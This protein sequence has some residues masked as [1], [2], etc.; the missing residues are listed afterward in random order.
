M[1]VGVGCGSGFRR[2]A[3]SEGLLLYYSLPDSDGATSEPS[4]SSLPC[5]R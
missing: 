1:E 3:E 4:Y 2:D 5:D